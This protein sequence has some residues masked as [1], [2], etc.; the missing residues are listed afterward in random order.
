MAPDPQSSAS[1]GDGPSG[2][3]HTVEHLDTDGDLAMLSG[4]AA[5]TELGS[6][7]VLVASHGGFG[8][9]AHAGLGR[10]LPPDAAPLGHELD[11]TVTL[12]VP[13]RISGAQH[14]VGAGWD[15]YVN[16]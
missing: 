13:I 14:G 3:G 16:P 7:Q 6:D 4:P 12:A 2:S 10:S 5:G 8:L 15:D 1:D 11:V 9:T